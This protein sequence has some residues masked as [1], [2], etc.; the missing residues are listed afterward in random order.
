MCK[1]IQSRHVWTVCWGCLLTRPWEGS[2]KYS[3]A[4]ELSKVMP[5]EAQSLA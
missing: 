5:R 4:L 3:A 1:H 2:T